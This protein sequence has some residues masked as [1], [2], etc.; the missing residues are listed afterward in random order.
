MC[1]IA[2]CSYVHP[3]L[4]CAFGG[5][6]AHGAYG[7]TD[8]SAYQSSPDHNASTWSLPDADPSAYLPNYSVVSSDAASSIVAA[9]TY[10]AQPQ[11]DAGEAGWTKHWDAAYGKEFYYNNVRVW[12]PHSTDYCFV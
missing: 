1:A 7:H 8:T 4:L 10:D 6:A 3:L 12:C 11:L 9:P 5:P 2:E